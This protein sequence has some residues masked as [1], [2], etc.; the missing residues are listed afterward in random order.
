MAN[1]KIEPM[2]LRGFLRFFTEHPPYFLEI[3][4][5]IFIVERSLESEVVATLHLERTIDREDFWEHSRKTVV[6]RPIVL[7]MLRHEK[8]YLLQVAFFVLE[9]K[10]RKRDVTM[11]ACL[12]HRQRRKLSY[13][14]MWFCN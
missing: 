13:L 5:T 7:F 11:L 14:M 9:Y 6:P 8:G 12:H 2:R 3:H 1:D 4:T 10:E